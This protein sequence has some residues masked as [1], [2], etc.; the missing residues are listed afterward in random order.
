MIAIKVILKNWRNFQSAEF[1]LGQRMFVVGPNASGK[2]NL[3]DVFRFL[4]DVAKRGGGLQKA[5]EERGGLARIRCLAA[6]RRPEVEIEIWLGDAPGAH[7]AWRYAIG[8]R[9]EVRGK[10]QGQ[11]HLK[12]ER[13]WSGEEKILDR[14]DELDRRDPLRLTQT[15]LEQIN[16]NER[17]RDIA[18]FA[19]STLY[20]HLVPQLLRH[21]QA[22][23]GPE[24][25]GDPF[26]RSF[27]KRLATTPEHARK[28]RLR[29][30]EQ[31]LTIAVPQMRELSY[32]EELGVP[33]LEALYEH[34]R[35]NAGW[36][37]EDQF[38]DG[39]LRLIGLL[40]SLLETDSL[41][42]LEEPELSLNAAIVSKLPAMMF[43]AQQKRRRQLLIS[44]HSVELLSGQSI[45]AEEVL[46]L[47]PNREGTT[48]SVASSIRMVKD[49]LNSGMSVGEAV[50]PTT[51]PSRVEQ[52]DL[53]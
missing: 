23:V 34:W 13:V 38:S 30:I 29:I 28:A 11:P 14:P 20:L 31:A 6:R 35:R 9:Q 19:S 52:L 21:P 1:E 46:L 53:W 4:R 22:F 44:T 16:S 25:S 17:F 40:W 41:L 8:L 49:L 24:L 18:E 51:R 36:Q 37:R 3:L 48:V 50:L 42:L 7:P 45:G 5:V 47:A 43:R 10:R 33:H 32:R 27:L 12:Y 15:H 2:S 26:G 39:T